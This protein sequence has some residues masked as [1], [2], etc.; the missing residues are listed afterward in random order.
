MSETSNPA[1][2]APEAIAAIPPELGGA[3]EPLSA[4]AA[5]E[6]PN[7]EKPSAEPGAAPEGATK[8]APES[9]PAAPEEKSAA[10]EL[11][12]LRAHLRHP[13]RLAQAQA[14]QETADKA[15]AEAEAGKPASPAPTEA[16]V[17]T[18]TPEEQAAGKNPDRVRIGSFEES[19]Q[20]L[21]LAATSLARSEK[22][23]VRAAMTRLLASPSAP[24]AAEAPGNA[25]APVK[26]AEAAAPAPDPVQT[27]QTRIADLTK[28]L[29]EANA[30]FDSEAA[31]AIQVE[32]ID[33]TADLKIM[34]SEQAQAAK[35]EKASYEGAWKSREDDNFKAM[36][37]AY[38][39]FQVPG[40][41]LNV[42]VN[43]R[44]AQL[45]RENPEFFN[46]PDWVRFVV[47]EQANK[48]GTPAAQ[49]PVRTPAAPAV[50]AK[51]P[52]RQAG[53]P[54]AIPPAPG[55]AGGGG[56]AAPGSEA[57]QVLASGNLKA[58]LAFL[59]AHGQRRG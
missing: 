10:A 58:G 8:P 9:A 15:A 22:I 30:A 38:P 24:A 19:D 23:T 11:R 36:T 41:P 18:P 27:Q 29:G 4:T 7:G 1:A 33:A 57:E 12:E 17:K 25:P 46:T 37:T 32:L 48:L 49:A 16:E 31:T 2:E 26:P 53:H 28:R 50:P 55:T 42:A 47:L 43:Q 44:M 59:R 6:A 20:D 21:I 13:E 39:E 56:I 54:A 14:D 52:P 3:P 51:T 35:T 34:K 45:E 5:P 40:S